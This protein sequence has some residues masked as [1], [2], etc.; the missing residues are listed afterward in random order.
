MEKEALEESYGM[1][2]HRYFREMPGRES[3]YSA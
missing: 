3:D 1:T 2:G